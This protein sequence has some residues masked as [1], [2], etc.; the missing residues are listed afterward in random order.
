VVSIITAGS[1]RVEVA[2]ISTFQAFWRLDFLAMAASPAPQRRMN[3]YGR[4]D[5]AEVISAMLHRYH[6]GAIS[7]PND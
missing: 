6:A 1:E 7:S 5:A 3:A 4:P 2:A